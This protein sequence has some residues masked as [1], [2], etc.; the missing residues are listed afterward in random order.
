MYK[1]ITQ[2]QADSNYRT[3]YMLNM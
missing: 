1:D 3:Y 2:K